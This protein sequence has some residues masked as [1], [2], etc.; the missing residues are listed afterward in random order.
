MSEEFNE[1]LHSLVF[2]EIWTMVT[3]KLNEG[4]KIEYVIP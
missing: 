2:E 3:L 4:A 1:N